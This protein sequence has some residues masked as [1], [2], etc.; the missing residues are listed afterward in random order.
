MIVGS[1]YQRLNKRITKAMLSKHPTAQEALFLQSISG[2]ITTYRQDARLTERS[3]LAVHD[4][5]AHRSNNTAD[6]LAYTTAHPTVPYKGRTRSGTNQ[7]ITSRPAAPFVA[8]IILNKPEPQ[9]RP[10]IIIANR[11]AFH[12]QADQQTRPV[13]HIDYLSGIP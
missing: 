7:T 13:R 9:R 2:S 3:Q 1:E 4:P 5:D 6:K 8:A 10:A 11:K 12:I